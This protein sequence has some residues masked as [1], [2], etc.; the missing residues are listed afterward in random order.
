MKITELP[1]ELLLH[2]MS[3]LKSYDLINLKASC[4][5]FKKIT[6][7]NYAKK[8]I[9]NYMNDKHNFLYLNEF[10]NHVYTKVM[11][12]DCPIKYK[13]KKNNDVNIVFNKKY[14]RKKNVFSINFDINNENK[15]TITYDAYRKKFFC[16]KSGCE[17]IS[18]PIIFFITALR[19]M[20]K[21]YNIHPIVYNF[22]IDENHLYILKQLNTNHNIRIIDEVLLDTIS[23]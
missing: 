22:T 5:R 4:K 3:Y 2:T 18:I 8:F 11:D 6:T 10:V 9:I 14:K 21:I 15:L 16:Q 19:W 13:L 1:T 7:I 17:K 12:N 20:I 23:I